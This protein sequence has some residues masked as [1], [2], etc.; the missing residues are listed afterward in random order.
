MCTEGYLLWVAIIKIMISINAIVQHQMQYYDIY[1][2]WKPRR[3]NCFHRR[4]PLQK[5]CALEVIASTTSNTGVV[6]TLK[7]ALYGNLVSSV[8]IVISEARSSIYTVFKGVGP[9]Y[10]ADNW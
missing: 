1:D 8:T 7:L 5:N 3:S 4:I 2:I 9:S 10:Q 6:A